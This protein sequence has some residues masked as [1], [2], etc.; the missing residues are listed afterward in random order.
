LDKTNKLNGIEVFL[1]V[2]KV[3][4]FS[5][6][7]NQLGLSKAM[8]S[9][10]IT[11]LENTLNVR[12]LNRT[13]RQI[14]M[15]EA[16]IS[17]RDRIREIMNDMTETE[18]SIAQLS[19]EPQG[20]LR[21]MAPTSFGSFH[22]ARAIADYRKIY[23]Q[24][25]IEII[26]TEREPDIIEDGLDM[27]IRVGILEDSS[28]VARKIADARMVVCASPEY[29]QEYGVPN[30]PNDL[31]EHN[32]L[33]YSGRQPM[34]EWRF[35]VNGKIKKLRVKGDVRSNVGDALRIAA[36]QG[37]G[38][39]QLP[40]YMMGLDIKHGWLTALLQDYD[41]PARPIHAIYL[42]RR[43][44]SAKVRTFVEFLYERYQPEPYW[45]HWT[46]GK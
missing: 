16:G 35:T 23:T 33:I 21:I 6:A 5:E 38:L 19:S 11:N 44:L 14:S 30:T 31:L 46:D 15:T 39:V 9:K 18:L 7:A 2:A 1:K 41:P 8:V 10:H 43:H 4:S 22:L 20:T 28:L 36:I 25:G 26:L 37:C 13:T 24:V 3:G 17:Y 34:G 40:T 32:C 12:L 45:E 42:H 27:V 29:L